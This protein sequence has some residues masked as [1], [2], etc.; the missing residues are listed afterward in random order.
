V[1]YI[2]PFKSLIKINLKAYFYLGEN[3]LILEG[4]T[5]FHSFNRMLKNG[6]YYLLGNCFFVVHLLDSSSI[7]FIFIASA[8]CNNDAMG[9]D[10][11]P[12]IDE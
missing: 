1:Q 9:A 4:P 6:N 8:S 10:K 3:K 7:S 2:E 12:F 11:L 5:F